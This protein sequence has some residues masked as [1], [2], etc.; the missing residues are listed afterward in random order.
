MMFIVS[1]KKR[2]GGRKKV[3]L[4]VCVCVKRIWKVNTHTRKKKKQG[5]TFIL[6]AYDFIFIK[7]HLH[8]MRQHSALYYFL[9]LF[10][11]IYTRFSFRRVEGGEE[12]ANLDGLFTCSRMANHVSVQHLK[13]LIPNA[14]TGERWV[15]VSLIRKFIKDVFSKKDIR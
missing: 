10:W 8:C 13:K 5:Y 7:N 3:G 15:D 6:I 11:Y 1:Q 12:D 4:C 14:F 9:N 2:N